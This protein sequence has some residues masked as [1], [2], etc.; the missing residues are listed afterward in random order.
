MKKIILYFSL[1]VALFFSGLAIVKADEVITTQP[2]EEVVEVEEQNEVVENNE[3]EKIDIIGEYFNADKVAMYMS[4]VA[5]IG[6]IIGL[7]VNFNKLKRSSNLTLKDAKNEF[8]QVLEDKIG[9]EVSEKINQFLPKILD[10]QEKTKNI[11]SIFAKVLALSQEN[12]PESR[13]AILNL[14]QELGVVGQEV[15]NNVKDV[16]DLEVKTAKEEKEK[17]DEKLD[18]LIEK[19]DGTTI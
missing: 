10:T 1:A 5:Y 9:V 8:T 2:N 7:V 16:I 18:N 19:Y 12:T 3:D 14:I 4:W 11:M 6:T 15:V 17:V 13:V